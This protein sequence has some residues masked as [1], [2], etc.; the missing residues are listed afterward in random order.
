VLAVPHPRLGEEVAA[1][2]VRTSAADV[3]AAELRRSAATE[4]AAFKVP[5]RIVFVDGIPRD[6]QGKLRRGVLDGLFAPI[7]RDRPRR[8]IARDEARLAAIWAEVLGLEHV[9][10]TDDFFDLGGD[11]L[12]AASILQ[13]VERELGARLPP[14][15]F[16]EAATV[17][18]LAAA[19]GGVPLTSAGPAVVLREGR[20]RPPF[21][22]VHGIGGAAFRL[23]ALARRLPDE[24]PFVALQ[25][26]GLDGREAPLARIDA[27]AELYLGAIAARQRRGPYL[28]GG[29][30]MGGAV[31]YEMACRLEARGEA[32]ALLALIDPPPLPLG[33][34]R[35]PQERLRVAASAALQRLRLR[36]PGPPIGE[37]ESPVMQANRRAL[38]RYRPG[39]YRGSVWLCCASDGPEGAAEDA[40]ASLRGLVAGSVECVSFPGGHID[41]VL[42]P[43]VERVAAELE[44]ALRDASAGARR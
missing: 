10:T 38:R 23:A 7:H 5:R 44:R 20:G 40:E 25:A 22:C 1:A 35:R 34:R 9:A 18:A 41:L 29:F 43:G 3:T 4:L 37:D 6:G 2:I 42:E 30:C 39:R 19:I 12:A 24:Q 8:P 36:A 21:F 27:L 33:F 13:R 11:S 32:V 16:F 17:E 15:V 26:P 31:A 14:S 28:L